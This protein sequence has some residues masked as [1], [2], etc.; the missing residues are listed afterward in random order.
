MISHVPLVLLCYH[1]VVLNKL[2]GFLPVSLLRGSGA[3]VETCYPT[4]LQND[5]IHCI[6]HIKKTFSTYSH[7]VQ[8]KWS[9]ITV[10]YQFYTDFRLICF[11]IA[12]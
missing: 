9:N 8:N 4:T 12:S 2:S 3:Q 6:S 11:I 5:Y 10:K 7:T 1:T